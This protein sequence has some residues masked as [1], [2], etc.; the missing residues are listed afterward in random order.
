MIRKEFEVR[1][2]AIIMNVF[3]STLPGWMCSNKCVIDSVNWII[4]YLFILYTNEFFEKLA[5]Y[6]VCVC[7]CV[8]VCVGERDHSSV[9]YGD[10]WFIFNYSSVVKWDLSQGFVS[11]DDFHFCLDHFSFKFTYFIRFLPSLFKS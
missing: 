11:N 10:L 1:G 8:G 2:L 9:R 7:M 4:I 5:D 3:E 6:F